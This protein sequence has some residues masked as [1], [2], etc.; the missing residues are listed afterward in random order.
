[1]KI[2]IIIANVNKFIEIR[3]TIWGRVEKL[4]VTVALVHTLEGVY[5][6]VEAMNKESLLINSNSGD[7][8]KRDRVA[9]LIVRRSSTRG[10]VDID[11]PD[12]Y[13]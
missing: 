1:M 3:R 7:D 8:L 11:L 6:R 2:L 13:M 12:E 9:I 10:T 4:M 5:N